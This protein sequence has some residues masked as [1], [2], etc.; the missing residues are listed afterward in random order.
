MMTVVNNASSTLYAAKEDGHQHQ[1]NGAESMAPQSSQYLGKEF[2][3]PSGDKVINGI[4]VSSNSSAFNG[5]SGDNHQPIT[6]E[7]YKTFTGMEVEFHFYSGELGP[8]SSNAKMI[9]EG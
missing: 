4:M 1:Y 9:W 3:I 8:R 5:G 6:T 2:D 7:F